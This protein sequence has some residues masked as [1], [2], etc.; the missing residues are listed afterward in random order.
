MTKL[1]LNC[2]YLCA[3]GEERLLLEETDTHLIYALE[4][5]E[6]CFEKQTPTPKLYCL[7]EFTEGEIIKKEVLVEMKLFRLCL[8]YGGSILVI[9]ENLESVKE[10][11]Q[12]AKG[13][14]ITLI[15]SKNE[16]VWELEADN[17]WAI[18]VSSAELHLED[19]YYHTIKLN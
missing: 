14:F 13:G 18:K 15:F 11:V 4:T 6:G 10:I 17:V 1:E 5:K 12:Q 19:T 16:A 7:H 8:K 2:L 9:G 3:D